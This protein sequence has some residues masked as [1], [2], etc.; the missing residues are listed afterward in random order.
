MS[1]IP[2]IKEFSKNSKYYNSYNLIQKKVVKKLL[3]TVSFKPKTILDLGC[4]DGLVYKNLG[5]KVD[6]FVGVDLSTLML[7]LHPKSSEVFLECKDF[8]S[9]DDFDKYDLVISSSSLQWSKDIYTLVK[10]IENNSQNF[11]L[12]IFTEGTFKTLRDW[13][14]LKSFLPNKNKLKMSFSKNVSCETISYKLEFKSTLEMLK[15]IKKSG[16]SGGRKEL[17]VKEIKYFLQNYDK[18]FLEFEVIQVKKF[19]M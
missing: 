4:G 18:D 17:K 7:D 14:G 6:K 5:F 11:A 19:N 1:Q 3:S 12:A 10:N 16:V 15:Y 9:V 13:F 2:H 8:D